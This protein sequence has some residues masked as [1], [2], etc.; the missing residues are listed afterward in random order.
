M[1][2]VSYAIP[3]GN[4]EFQEDQYNALTQLMRSRLSTLVMKYR[5]KPDGSD[6]TMLILAPV[7]AGLNQMFCGRSPFGNFL[8]L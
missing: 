7:E 2:D 8:M 4:A 3:F 5:L 6:L 1:H